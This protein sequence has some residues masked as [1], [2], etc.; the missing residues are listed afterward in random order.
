MYCT[1]SAVIYKLTNPLTMYSW[2]CFC[3]WYRDETYRSV[4]FLEEENCGEVFNRLW[5]RLDLP[6]DRLDY[7]FYI[8]Y[9]K[10][11]EVL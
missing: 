1:Y 4:R 9:R 3:C 6:G 5:P 7:Q 2:H 10:D 11:G 8:V